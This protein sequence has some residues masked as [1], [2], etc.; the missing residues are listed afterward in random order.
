MTTLSREQG[1]YARLC[2]Q[3]DFT[4]PLMDMFAIKGR[5]FK[6]QYEG[7]HLL[8]LKYGKYGHSTEGCGTKIEVEMYRERV[9]KSGPNGLSSSEPHNKEQEAQQG[10]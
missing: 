3:V 2:I 4:K 9:T 6:I 1:K 10:P 7:L 5:N 8:C